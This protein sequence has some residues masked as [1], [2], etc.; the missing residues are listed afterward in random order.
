MK[1][2]FLFLSLLPLY[3]FAQVQV[4]Y[5]Y[6][7][8][9]LVFIYGNQLPGDVLTTQGKIYGSDT[10]FC[11][12]DF[13]INDS[14]EI[15]LLQKCDTCTFIDCTFGNCFTDGWIVRLNNI[16]AY[17]AVYN[18]SNV[19]TVTYFYG[20]LRNK[21][22]HNIRS[23]FYIEVIPGGNYLKYQTK[24]YCSGTKAIISNKHKINVSRC[25]FDL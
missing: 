20:A 6:S 3:L 17:L 11:V 19:N 16:P 22:N 24:L 12:T 10:I 5:S 13:N 7:T 4:N 1:I 14:V 8:D 18:L 21:Y 25:P 15:L 9:R 2:L 23:W